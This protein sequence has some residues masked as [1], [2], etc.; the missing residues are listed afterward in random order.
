M[1][2]NKDS[3]QLGLITGK[4][5]LDSWKEIANYLD[6]SEKTCR[7]WENE[8]CLPIHRLE[9]SPKARVLAYKEELD[10]WMK[11][12]LSKTSKNKSGKHN[13]YIT[14]EFFSK[15]GNIIILL[16]L[17]FVLLMI[18]LFLLGG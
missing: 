7:K 15:K 4:T 16:V 5:V 9:D 1:G 8:L 3:Y 10:E 12:K 18:F 14:G 11:E 2:V 6:R 17:S 13:I